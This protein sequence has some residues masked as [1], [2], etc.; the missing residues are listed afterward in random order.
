MRDPAPAPP[1]DRAVLYASDAL[2]VSLASPVSSPAPAPPQADVSKLPGARWV[3]SAAF[4]SETATVHAGCVRGPSGRYAPGVED[5]LLEKASFFAIRSSGLEGVGLVRTD[6]HEA[7]NLRTETH[8]GELAGRQVRLA[9]ALAFVGPDSDV[10]ICSATCHGASGACASLGLQVGGQLA[11]P[12]R[13]SWLVRA[14]FAA[15]ENPLAVTITIGLL[16]VVIVAILL[17]KRPRP[18]GVDAPRLRASSSEGRAQ[19]GISSSS[20]P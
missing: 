6:H 19:N 17:W 7:A 14:T 10:L 8:A 15:A 2:W 20:P 3:A 11:P 16:G 13:P 18:P 1:A 5:L 4:A 9:H 12:P